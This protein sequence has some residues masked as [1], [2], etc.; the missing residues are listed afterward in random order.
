MPKEEETPS[1][2]TDV[3]GG[4]ESILGVM[5]NGQPVRNYRPGW[6]KRTSAIR[7]PGIQDKDFRFY[8]SP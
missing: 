3:H 2:R 7:V 4:L 8:R 1:S 5:K 6:A